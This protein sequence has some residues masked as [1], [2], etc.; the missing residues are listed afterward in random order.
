MEDSSFPKY[1]WDPVTEQITIV[2]TGR[3]FLDPVTAEPAKLY[4]HDAAQRFIR[5]QNLSGV[6]GKLIS[7][8]KSN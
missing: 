1:I 5:E 4:D 3:V 2:R 6:V 8:E 7:S